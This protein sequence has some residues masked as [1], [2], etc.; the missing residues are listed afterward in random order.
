M[1]HERLRTTEAK[2]R[3]LR[4]MAERMVTEA[5]KGG[6]S[7]RRRLG[8]VLPEKAARKLI[9]QIAPKFAARNGGYTRIIRMPERL[10][11]SSRRA[12]LEFVQ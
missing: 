8:R 11:D 1:L 2:A 3:E 4:P 12:I 5:K 6:L 10:S 7:A 9:G